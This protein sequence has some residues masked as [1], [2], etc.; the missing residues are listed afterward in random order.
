MQSYVVCMMAFKSLI[1]PRHLG[2]PQLSWLLITWFWIAQHNV[3]GRLSSLIS[4]HGFSFDGTNLFD[5]SFSDHMDCASHSQEKLSQAHCLMNPRDH[6][7]SRGFRILHRMI[8]IHSAG[9][10]LP[11]PL[12]KYGERRRRVLQLLKRAAVRGP[13]RVLLSLSQRGMPRLIVSVFK[14]HWLIIV[15]SVAAIT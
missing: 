6:S 12:C 11:L 1:G 4:W 7:P 8:A 3:A 2:C 5:G 14:L 13:H 15:L 9:L 10:L